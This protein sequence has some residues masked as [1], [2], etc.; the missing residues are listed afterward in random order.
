MAFHFQF[1]IEHFC[2]PFRYSLFYWLYFV[3][4]R[5]SNLTLELS[6]KR[7]ERNETNKQTKVLGVT[8]MEKSSRVLVDFVWCYIT[9]YY[10]FCCSYTTCVHVSI[11]IFH[12]LQWNG[13]SML[14]SICSKAR[15][16]DKQKRKIPIKL[17]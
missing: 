15:Y 13:L 16:N 2:L 1:F 10:S 8:G 12:S 4:H 6:D 7:R 9:Y 14:C 11:D 17:C 3:I 5:T